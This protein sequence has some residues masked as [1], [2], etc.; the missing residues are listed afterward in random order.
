MIDVTACSRLAG[1]ELRI[2]RPAVHGGRPAGQRCALLGTATDQ[3]QSSSAKKINDQGST[4][5]RTEPGPK[6][7][8]AVGPRTLGPDVRPFGNAH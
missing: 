4:W 3:E 6:G 7:A 5:R 8:G 1:V 2:L